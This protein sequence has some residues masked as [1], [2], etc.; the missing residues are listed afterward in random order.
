[1]RLDGIYPTPQ[2]ADKPNIE[3]GQVE[4]IGYN[5]NVQTSKNSRNSVSFNFYVTV[6]ELKQYDMN[7]EKI[8]EDCIIDLLE[9]D[10]TKIDSFDAEKI[11]RDT[12]RLDEELTKNSESATTM[13][14]ELAIA[15]SNVNGGN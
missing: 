11:K 10:V 4:V 3:T 12:A 2:I 15:L 1:M 14:T 8:V 6:E 7:F 9:L 5:I 13:I